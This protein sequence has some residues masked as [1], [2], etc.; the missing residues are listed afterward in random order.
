M[1]SRYLS[2]AAF[3]ALGLGVLVGCG[4]SPAEKTVTQT[5]RVS[6]PEATTPAMPAEL[7]ADP[8]ADSRAATD[9]LLALDDFPS[10]WVAKPRTSKR[11][12]A[13]CGIKKY[14]SAIATSRS[15][16]RNTDSVA[17][18]VIFAN[19][20]EDAKVAFEVLN[21]GIGACLKEGA[22]ESDR[23]DVTIGKID[24]SPMS[25][26]PLGDES[27]GVRVEVPFDSNGFKSTLVDDVVFTR[28]GRV[29]ASTALAG[30]G[31]SSQD[32]L[33]RLAGATAGRIARADVGS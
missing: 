27:S 21:D 22:I 26:D 7:A 20:E 13:E 19:N 8:V 6:A 30:L 25:V 32:L 4:N 18:T 23:D 3:A 17:S 1:K 24:V 33:S 11:T 12:L 5:V 31:S 29:I 16:E 28:T 14:I 15:F 2:L 9:A 10:G